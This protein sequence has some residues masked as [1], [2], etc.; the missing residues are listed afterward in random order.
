MIKKIK[1]Y[2]TNTYKE[3]L[4]SLGKEAEKRIEKRVG[5]LLENPNIA[6]PMMYQHKGYCEIKVGKKYRVYCIKKRD[7]IG[8]LFILGPT[9]HHKYNYKKSDKY[10]QIFAVLEELEKEFNQLLT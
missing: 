5:K 8:L 10:K 3:N 1:V 7:K 9:I 4:I 6:E 2:K